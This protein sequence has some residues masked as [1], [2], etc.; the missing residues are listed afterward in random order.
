MVKRSRTSRRCRNKRGGYPLYNDQQPVSYDQQPVSYDQQPVSYG[1]QPANS[2]SWSDSI[3]NLFGKSAPEAPVDPQ[4]K[5]SWYDIFGG[6]RR[7]KSRK[8]RKTYKK[9]SYRK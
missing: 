9:R 3:T 8:N 1:Q 6:K 7:T 4:A 5:K 2:S